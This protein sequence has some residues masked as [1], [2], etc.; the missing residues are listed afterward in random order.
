MLSINDAMNKAL[1]TPAFERRQ[2]ASMPQR[3]SVDRAALRL[4][5]ARAS[6]SGQRYALAHALGRFFERACFA[7]ASPSFR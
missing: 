6:S 4:V 1:A 3:L 2:E 5:A 7:G